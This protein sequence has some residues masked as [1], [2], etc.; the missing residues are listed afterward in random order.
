VS[1]PWLLLSR[2]GTLATMKAIFAG[3]LALAGAA[4]LGWR[5]LVGRTGER[6]VCLACR[7]RGVRLTEGGFGHVTGV[8][9]CPCREIVPC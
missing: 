4:A 8:T 3:G 1:L 9:P 2:T 7:D 6:P 5:A